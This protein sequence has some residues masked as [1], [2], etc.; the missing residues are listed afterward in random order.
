MSHAF[1]SGL[2]CGIGIGVAST[3]ALIGALAWVLY[4]FRTF[5]SEGS[6]G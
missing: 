3:A 6:E 4:R 1:L 5:Y 2:F